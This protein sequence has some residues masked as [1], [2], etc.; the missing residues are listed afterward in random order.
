[1]I[2]RHRKSGYGDCHIKRK[3]VHEPEVDCIPMSLNEV[4]RLKY[5]FAGALEFARPANTSSLTGVIYSHY[6]CLP[7]ASAMYIWACV[8]AMYYQ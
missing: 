4:R 1:M 3:K 5:F 6:S 2:L 7:P 8:K